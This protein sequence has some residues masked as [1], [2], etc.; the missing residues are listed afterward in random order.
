VELGAKPNHRAVLLITG[1]FLANAVLVEP[2]GWPLSGAVLFWTAAYALGSRRHIL[3]I[4]I[5]FALS[6]GSYLMFAMALGVELPVGPL[7]G[8]L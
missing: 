8:L 7:G 5:A 3:N 6:I 4:F 2:L 1:S